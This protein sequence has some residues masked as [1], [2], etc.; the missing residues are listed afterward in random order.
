[1][2]K[3][4]GETTGATDQTTGEATGAAGQQNVE[5]NLTEREKGL[6]A[7][8]QAETKKRQEV[9]EQAAA[10]EQ[11]LQ[12]ALQ[13]AQANPPQQPQQPTDEFSEV[14]DDEMVLGK[15]AK[16]MVTKAVQKGMQ[17]IMQGVQ[18]QVF[19]G[20]HSDFADIVG[21]TDPV[22]NQLIPA[23]PLKAALKKDPLLGQA[24]RNNP[25]AHVIAYALA[26]K[27][28]ELI[29]ARKGTPEG[30]KEINDDA[31]SRINIAN[32]NLSASAAAG[33]GQ[34]DKV[35]AIANMTD[36][37]LREHRQQVTSQG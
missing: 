7:A 21:S 31:A 30:Q 37:Q 25:Q 15:E 22:T 16:T 9:E 27:E 26:S 32:Q 11:Y 1:M 19:V 18:F 6:L 4:T 29:E 34:M 23:A 28:K 12:Q 3:E 33:G 8:K 14:A 10:R 5:E 35:G 20:Q 2:A 24:L 13:V 36:E 17:A